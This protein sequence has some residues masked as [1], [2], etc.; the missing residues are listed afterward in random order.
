MGSS[1][2]LRCPADTQRAIIGAIQ[3]GNELDFSRDGVRCTHC[4]D[5]CEEYNPRISTRNPKLK[6]HIES[7]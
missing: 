2:T 7:F 1:Q 4:I 6:I 3:I 5:L